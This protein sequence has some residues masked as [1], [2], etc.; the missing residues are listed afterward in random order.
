[1]H[2]LHLEESENSRRRKH[3][4]GIGTEHVLVQDSHFGMIVKQS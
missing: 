2:W 4:D 1:M 3:G